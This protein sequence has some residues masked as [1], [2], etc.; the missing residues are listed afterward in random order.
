[1]NFERIETNPANVQDLQKINEYIYRF[2]GS[3]NYECVFQRGGKRY[4]ANVL[5]NRDG[6]EFGVATIELWNERRQ[7]WTHVHTVPG[8]LMRSRTSGLS[9]D[10]LTSSLFAEDL[11]ELVAVAERV[12]G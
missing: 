2:N 9:D 1:M 5:S 4:R 12:V 11:A 10:Q 3:P 7:D 8:P 6:M